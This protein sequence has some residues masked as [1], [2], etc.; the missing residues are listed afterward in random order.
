M[1]VRVARILLFAPIC[2]TPLL[3]QRIPSEQAVVTE[4]NGARMRPAAFARYLTALLPYFDGKVLRKPGEVGLLTEEG[5]TAV[6]EAIV[7]LE[8]ADPL[9][10]LEHSPVL[11]AAAR[12]HALDQ[13][14]R[15]A[16]GHT[17]SDGSTMSDR[18]SRYGRWTG[19]IAENIDYGSRIARDVVI[20]L[21][22]DDG[23]PSRGHR[24]NIF[25]P[26]SRHVG[27]ACGVHRQ[28]G[29]MCVIDYATGVQGQ[30]GGQLRK[31]GRR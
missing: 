22:V 31:R 18:I 8:R 4:M 20:S 27:V 12:A 28:Y 5:A 29:T 21:I 10:A 15:G 2:S 17:G 1:G 23:V 24:N 26:D 11:A 16:L 30:R 13:G 9:S 14:P 7:F 25:N 6:R 19:S 3:A